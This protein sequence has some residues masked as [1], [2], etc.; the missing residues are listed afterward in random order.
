MKRGTFPV[1]R[2]YASLCLYSGGS[3]PLLRTPCCC[4]T[5][6]TAFP[7]TYKNIAAASDTLYALTCDAVYAFAGESAEPARYELSLPAETEEENGVETSSLLDAIAIISHGG[8]LCLL[9]AQTERTIYEED[10]ETIWETAIDGVS[11]YALDLA[12]D[13][14]TIG[15]EVCVL[16]WEDLIFGGA[17]DAYLAE[18]DG[19]CASGDFLACKSYDES[20]NEFYAIADLT[21]GSVNLLLSRTSCPARTPCSRPTAM[22]NCS[23]SPANGGARATFP[24]STASIPQAARRTNFAPSP[25]AK[26]TLKRPLTGRKA[27][28]S[29]TSWTANSGRCGHGRLPERGRGRFPARFPA[30]TG[31]P[32][33]QRPLRRRRLF[34]PRAPR[35]RPR[36]ARLR[37]PHRAVRPFGKRGK[38]RPT[39]S[40][41]S[42]AMWK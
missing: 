16:D 41:R 14:A 34:H 18:V 17:D 39:P 32:Q 8:G 28:P 31:R 35:Y 19:L 10:G 13:A 20:G 5:A 2:F 24:A 6:R 11:L 25:P 3:R 29:T 4:A 38:R 30:R 9:A 7:A 15:A 23:A 21:D 36:A 37:A 26:A 22:G 40:A 27:I 1:A 33:R 12:G 42:A